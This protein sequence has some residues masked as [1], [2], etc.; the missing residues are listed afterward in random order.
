[1]L[2]SLRLLTLASLVLFPACRGDDGGGDDTTADARIDGP[3]VNGVTIQEV[4]ND[5]MVPGTAVEL[6][7]KVVTAIDNFGDRRGN[8]FVSEPGGGEF[9]GVLVFGAPADQVAQ[10]AVGDLVDVS[11]GEKTEFALPA[12]MSGRTTT[13]IQKIF[14]GELT[15]TKVGTGAVPPPHELDLLTV[16]QMAPAARDAEYEKWEG[17]LITVRNA[18]VVDAIFGIRSGVGADDCTFRDFGI[19]GDYRVD[20]SLAAIPATLLMTDECDAIA[21][22]SIVVLGDCVASVT[23]MSDYFFSHKILP[24]STAD[25]VTGGAACPPPENTMALCMD[26]ID[27]DV[28]GFTDCDDRNCS[29]FC[30]VGSTIELVQTGAATG[31]VTLDNVIVS[32]VDTIGSTQGIWIQQAAQA[33]ANQ[34]V[35]VFTGNTAPAVT[36]GAVVDVTGNVTEFDVNP[37]AGDTLTEITQATVTPQVGTMTPVAVPGIAVATLADIAALGEPYESVLV[38]LPAVRVM[39]EMPPGDRVIL[40]DGTN[41]IVMDDDIFNYAAGAYPVGTCFSGAVGIMTVNLFDDQRRFLPRAATDLTMV[42]CP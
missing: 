30:A 17:V 21:E 6:R 40:T 1:M 42:T 4:Q 20:S 37:V 11:G 27:N 24:R 5:A 10:L 18:S 39:L 36:I 28:N 29:A 19:M 3:G 13:E 2:R 7:G 31:T 12:D 16:G 25:I 38:R 34:G 22:P 23:G 35:F 26:T 32:G 8:F 15:V 14:G 33:A 41:T 9:S